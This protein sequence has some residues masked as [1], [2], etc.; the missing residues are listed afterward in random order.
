MESTVKLLLFFAASL[1]LLGQS[2]AAVFYVDGRRGSN[3]NDGLAT[4]TAFLTIQTCVDALNAPGDECHI[5]AGRYHEEVQISGKTGSPEKP[6]IIRGYKDEIPIIDGT[7]LL[8][9]KR[10]RKNRAGTYIGVLQRDIW[11]LFV[12]DVMMTNARWPN[13][14]WSDKTVFLNKHWAKA[15]AKLNRGTIT[16]DGTMDLAGSGLDATGAIAVLN[17]GSYNTFTSTVLSHRPGSKSFEYKDTFGSLHL[18]KFNQYFLEDKLDFLDQ[19]G[20]WFFDKNTKKLYVKTYNGQKPRTM[21][22]KVMRN[23]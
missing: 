14:L 6:I 17:I 18:T 10:W 22:G 12:D 5:R 23:L 15:T 16:D 13:A 3:D 8:N 1:V 21:R 7:V 2:S 11:Q 20:E 9:P 19:E 4:D